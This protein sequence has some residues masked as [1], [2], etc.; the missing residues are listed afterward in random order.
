LG[1]KWNYINDKYV[2]SIDGDDL[3]EIFNMNKNWLEEKV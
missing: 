3:D 1:L 2:E